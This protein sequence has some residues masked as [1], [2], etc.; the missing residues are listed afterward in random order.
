MAPSLHMV[1]VRK[2]KGDTLEFHKVCAFS[3]DTV[4]LE[5]TYYLPMSFSVYIILLNTRSPCTWKKILNNSHVQF[6]DF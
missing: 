6:T 2:T 1:E 5:K 4:K 3:V